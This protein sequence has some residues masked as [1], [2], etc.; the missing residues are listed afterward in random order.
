[1]FNRAIRYDKLKENPVGRVKKLPENNVRMKILSLEEFERLYC[2]CPLHLK[3]VVLV[4]YFTGMRRSEILNLTWGD[5][6]LNNGFV[7]LKAEVTKTKRLVQFLF[8]LK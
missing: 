1:M 7:R 3:S 8:I 6:D 2:Q 5:V 4:A